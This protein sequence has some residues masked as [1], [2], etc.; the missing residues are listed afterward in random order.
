MTLPVIALLGRKDEPTDAVEEYCRYLAEAL[1]AHDVQMELRRVPWESRGWAEALRGLRLQAASWRGR[2][3]L[4]QY[5]ALAW[6]KRG[7]PQKF[8]RVLK[9]LKGAGARVAVVFHDFEPYPGTRM[10]DS[11]RGAMQVRTMRRALRLADLAVFTVAPEKLSWRPE[12]DAH[13]AFV[14]VGA[15]LPVPAEV[16]A[17]PVQNEI[18]TIGVFSITGGDKGAR[19]TESILKAVR[20]AAQQVGRLRLSVFGRHAELRERDLRDG[21]RDLPVEVS[22]E[23]VITPAAVVQRLSACDVL[24]FVRGSISSG[25]GSAIAGIAC[26]VPLIAFLSGVTAS[27]ITE[28]GVLLLPP[29]ARDELQQALVRVLSDAELRATLRLRNSMV[30]TEYLSWPAIATRFAAL[31]RG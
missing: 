20:H 18:P 2:W 3:I 25:R 4:V 9:I 8:L 1:K 21:L 11:F 6:S 23:G 24:L 30:Y 22:V 5:T 16:S 17:R 13:V 31:L 15:N 14:P 26:G 19:E 12:I 29:D 28:A 27:P 7:F 10:I